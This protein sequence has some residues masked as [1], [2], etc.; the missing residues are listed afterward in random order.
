MDSSIKTWE[1]RELRKPSCEI[2]TSS[3]M[4]RAVPPP[5]PPKVNAG[6][7]RIGQLPISSAAAMTSSMELHATAWLM[8]KLIDS[9]T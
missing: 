8:G 4:S 1:M 6:R 9:Q 7:M 5:N 3:P 2:S